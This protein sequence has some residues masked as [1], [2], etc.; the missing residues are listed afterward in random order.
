MAWSTLAKLLARNIITDEN[1]ERFMLTARTALQY[2]K[3]KPNV[4]NED[5]IPLQVQKTEELVNFVLV[6]RPSSPVESETMFNIFQSKNSAYKNYN[7]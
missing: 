7:L 4:D 2:I 1:G 5:M 6:S 3:A